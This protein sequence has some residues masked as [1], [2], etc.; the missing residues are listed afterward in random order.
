M[1][2]K[3]SSQVEDHSTRIVDAALALASEGGFDNVRQREVAA[4]AGVTVRTLYRKFPSKHELLAAGLLRSVDELDRRLAD[5]PIRQRTPHA[6][7]KHLFLEMTAVFCDDAN[8]GRAIVQGLVSGSTSSA[9]PALSYFS[10]VLALVLQALRGSA[11]TGEASTLDNERALLLL[12]IWFSGM[13]SW[14]GGMV[15]RSGIEALVD[16][17]IRHVVRE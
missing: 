8:K 16:I 2:R 14:L 1:P 11:A 10:R 4:R 7:L 9:Q 13:V 15:D 12:Q 6:R 17:G 3:K 5:R